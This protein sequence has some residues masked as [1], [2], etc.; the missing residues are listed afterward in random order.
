MAEAVGERDMG[1]NEGSLQFCAWV[2]GTRDAGMGMG[3]SCRERS[4][5]GVSG[6]I[7]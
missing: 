4:N 7:F 5:T 2:P 6:R 1:K 3:D